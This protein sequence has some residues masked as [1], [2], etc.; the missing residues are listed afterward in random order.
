MKKRKISIRAI[1]SIATMLLCIVSIFYFLHAILL[2][3]GIEN[4]IR[5]VISFI[6]IVLDICLIFGFIRSIKEKNKW[7]I[8]YTILGI[9]YI[10]ILFIFGHYIIKTYKV[11]DNFTTDSTKYSSSLVTLSNNKTDDILDVNGINLMQIVMEVK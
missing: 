8:L 7:Y 10:L 9:I 3:N 4:M 6:L 1:I 11:V 2:L 5:I